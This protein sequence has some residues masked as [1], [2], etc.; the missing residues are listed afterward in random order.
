MRQEAF[1]VAYFSNL[2]F[3]LEI[4]ANFTQVLKSNAD[5]LHIKPSL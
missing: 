1:D 3:N 2:Q 5:T 4:F